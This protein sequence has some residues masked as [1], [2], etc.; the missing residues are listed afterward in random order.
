[1]YHNAGKTTD[2]QQINVYIHKHVSYHVVVVQLFV[3]TL[4]CGCVGV[5][6][7]REERHRIRRQPNPECVQIA[8]HVHPRD[9]APLDRKKISMKA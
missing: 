9:I 4:V 3:L 2:N 1:M 7:L 6:H 5:Q 8:G